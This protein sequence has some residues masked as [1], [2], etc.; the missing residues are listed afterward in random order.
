MPK[1]EPSEYRSLEEYENIVEVLHAFSGMVLFEF[2]KHETAT[3]EIILRNFVAR[4][5][6]MVRAVLTLWKLNDWQDA[7]IIYRALLDRLFH[8][9]HLGESDEFDAFS[10]W[11]FFQQFNALN[12]LRSDPRFVQALKLEG[13]QPTVKQKE[14]V[15]ELSKNPPKWKRPKAERV[16]RDM[17]LDFLY[18]YGYDLASTHVHPMANDGQEDFYTITGI[19][20]STQF[21]NQIAVLSNSI[22][23]GLLTIQDC[24]N[25]SRFKWRRLVFDQ[26]TTLLEGV[27]TGSKDYQITF[28]KLANFSMQGHKLCQ[29]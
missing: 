28:A 25:Y 16:A 20:P 12:A 10:D 5:Y 1:F 21:P 18:K 15:R 29:E 8:V 3:R 4:A 11:S 19:E 13:F 22:L 2:A 23:V 6:V 24:L 27:G 7:F 26:V 17:D 9:H 14:R